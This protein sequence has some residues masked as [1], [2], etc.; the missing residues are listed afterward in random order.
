MPQAN[1]IILAQLRDTMLAAGRFDRRTAELMGINTTDL[2]CLNFVETSPEPVTAKMLA[3]Y[4]GI[5]SG[6][7]TALID[8][9]E[10]RGLLARQNHPTDRRGIVVVAGPAAN[11]PA[12]VS[13]RARFREVADM[14]LADLGANDKA[15]I[16]TFLGRLIATLDAD[17]ATTDRLERP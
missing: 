16:T 5:S 13:L 4:V 6:S 7:T 12:V 10:R 14:T 15:V 3:D 8:R 2:S 11:D 1:E 9:L 17:L